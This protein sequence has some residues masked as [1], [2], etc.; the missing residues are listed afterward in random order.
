MPGAARLS[1]L[2][3]SFDD[4]R[5][6]LS[7]GRCWRR[8]AEVQL[9]HALCRRY[10]TSMNRIGSLLKRSLVALAMGAVLLVGGAARAAPASSIVIPIRGTA[11]AAGL[12]GEATIET[13]LVKDELGG[14][15][16]VLVAIRMSNLTGP[17]IR[18]SG[19]AVLVRP[20]VSSDTVELVLAVEGKN[21]S[22]VTARFALSLDTTTGAALRATASLQ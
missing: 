14:A 2:A 16:S 10:R 15:P 18:A 20:L 8:F 1:G 3:I 9:F 12:I 17:G 21:T 22:A 7:S 5:A 6:P 4:A 19:E 11:S 13:T